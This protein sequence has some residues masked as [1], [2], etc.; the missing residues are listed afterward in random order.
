MYFKGGAAKY[1]NNSLKKNSANEWFAQA[2]GAVLTCQ[3]LASWMSN[4]KRNAA[5]AT[6]NFYSN[7]IFQYLFL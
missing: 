2:L 7:L 5:V 3:A 4:G 1:Q 6:M